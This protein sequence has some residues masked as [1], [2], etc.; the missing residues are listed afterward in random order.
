MV[1]PS[2]PARIVGK[3]SSGRGH[4]LVKNVHVVVVDLIGQCSECVPQTVSVRDPPLLASSVSTQVV[5]DV[6][7]HPWTGSPDRV[8]HVSVQ[9]VQQVE[10]SP[11]RNF[12]NDVD[13]VVSTPELR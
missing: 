1:R 5:L 11:L 10:E 2:T 13:R 4:Y 3:G 6:V 7:R 12:H 8:V 9:V